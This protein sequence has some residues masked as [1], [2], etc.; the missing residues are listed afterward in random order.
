MVKIEDGN[1][2][3]CKPQMFCIL[4]FFLGSIFSIISCDN[5]VLIVWLG[6]GTKIRFLSPKTQ[7][8]IPQVSS[9]FTRWKCWITVL[10]SSHW[11]GS[12][13]ACSST[14]RS[15]RKHVMQTWYGTHCRIVN[16]VHM[17]FKN[18]NISVLCRNVN[19]QRF[20]QETGLHWKPIQLE[21]NDK[22]HACHLCVTSYQH[23]QPHHQV[24]QVL[25]K[26]MHN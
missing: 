18:A 1:L 4:H 24:L 8:E 25:D 12:L 5:A 22:R 2:C 6:L 9:D 10:N 11:L 21:G 19:C 20:F 13:L 23:E 3:F 17:T 7:L 16:T 15:G 26:Q 14:N